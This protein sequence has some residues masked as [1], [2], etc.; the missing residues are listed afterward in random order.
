[1]KTLGAFKSTTMP[2]VLRLAIAVMV[3]TTVALVAAVLI[4]A[5]NAQ[6]DSRAKQ[7]QIDTLI[8][9]IR[10]Q[11]A[12]GHQERMN[13]EAGIRG[14][15]ADVSAMAQYT[16]MTAAREEALL[17]YLRAH[18]I[19]LPTQLVT[20]IPPPVLIHVPGRTI[21]KRVTSPPPKAGKHY[22]NPHRKHHGH[23]GQRGQ[24]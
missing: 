2:R 15:T 1:M 24:Q 8:T 5:Y 13:L 9:Y 14:L 18:G 4:F 20:V 12:Q 10:S 23:G 19:K 3:M 6:Q 22:V 21:I 17:Q 11:N 7:R 16:S